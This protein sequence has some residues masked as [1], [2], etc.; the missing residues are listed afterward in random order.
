MKLRLFSFL[1][2]ATLMF[3]C[4]SDD[5]NGGTED[6]AGTYNLTAFNISEPQ[7]L[8]GDGTASTN[9]LSETSCFNGSFVTLNANN[10]FTADGKGMELE[11]DNNGNATTISCYDDGVYTGTW[12]RSGNT[13]TFTYMDG[14]QSYTD[15]ASFVGNTIKFTIPD[16]EVVGMSQGNPVY[17]TTDLELVYTKS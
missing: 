13:I 2:I 7:D 11:F 9:Q 6:V 16:G 8:N 10:T 12:A 15:T 5:D 4:S 1:A 3:A 17:L 14:T